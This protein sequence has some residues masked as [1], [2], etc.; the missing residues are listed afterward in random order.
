[1]GTKPE[2]YPPAKHVMRDL[3]ITTLVVS[4]SRSVGLVPLDAAVRSG[5][6][7][8]L[9]LLS[10]VADT[11]AAMVALIAGQPDWI[12]TVDLS[13]HELG[14][15]TAPAALVEARLVRAGSNIV[16]VAADSFAVDD[17]DDGIVRLAERADLTKVSTGM[18]SFARIPA[19]A[20]AASV[21]LKPEQRIGVVSPTAPGEPERR[22]LLERIGLRVID[23][24]NGV[25]EVARTPYVGNSFGAV[26]GGV[27]GMIFQGAAE[28][29][30][31]GWRA[32]DVQIHYLAQA[33][34]GPVRT[35]LTPVR[36][37]A[38]HAVCLVD[39]VDAGHDDQLLATA[40]VVVRRL[41]A[42]QPG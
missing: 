37:D 15:C 24:A 12:A 16:V 13:L 22:P 8:A 31:P 4:R 26:N 40:T 33:K 27:L 41:P 5:G 29:A 18:V 10:I 11:Q 34:S 2:T 23:A 17:P 39:A 6:A 28:A 35:R 21:S 14:P 19:S 1:M 20:S 3:D 38:T 32:A 42:D 36:A 25:V 30:H 9:G 7:A